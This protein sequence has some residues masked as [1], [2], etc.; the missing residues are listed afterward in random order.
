MRKN[1]SSKPTEM[2]KLPTRWGNFDT[3]CESM[4]TL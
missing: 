3:Q 1:D 4:H 2:P